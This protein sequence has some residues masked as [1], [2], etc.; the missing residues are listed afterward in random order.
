MS[1]LT[2]TN[3]TV[4]SSTQCVMGIDFGLSDNRI[5]KT[6]SSTYGAQLNAQVTLNL[7]QNKRLSKVESNCGLTSDFIRFCAVNGNDSSETCIN[8]GP[9][10]N[11][12]PNYFVY[13][14]NTRIILD[15]IYGEY[16]N[17][18]AWYCLLNIGVNVVANDFT[19]TTNSASIYTLF[20]LLF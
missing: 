6:G 14:N 20:L 18:F 17:Y 3:L 5:I 19:S 12:L 15:S 11:S 4:Y 13:L 7:A 1:T 10:V 16:F 9:N 2:L 8:T